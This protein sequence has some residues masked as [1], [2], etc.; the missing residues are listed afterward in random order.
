[1]LQGE[2]AIAACKQTRS[3]DSGS[4]EHSFRWALLPKTPGFSMAS[5]LTRED[6]RGVPG[7]VRLHSCTG[8]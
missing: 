2:A 4:Y 6:R 5:A 8:I 3:I 7:S 1:M